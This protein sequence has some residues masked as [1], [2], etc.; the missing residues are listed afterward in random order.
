M[1][2]KIW[3]VT[4]ISSGLGRA[5]AETLMTHDIFVIGTFRRKE[6]VNEFN[7]KHN[8]K[9]FAVHLELDQKMEMDTIIARVV[10]RFGHIDVLVNNAG[11]GFAGA[12]EEASMEEVRA[13]F[14][15]NFFGVMQLT[16]AVLP[17]MRLRGEGHIIQI[18]SHGG[19]E[20]FCR[21]WGV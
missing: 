20:G 15:V 16:K 8:G 14:E 4:G 2:N 10:E 17:H 1:E 5:L 11:Y 6:E 18:S 7:E 19:S 9:G 12:I 13:V 21:F 3:F